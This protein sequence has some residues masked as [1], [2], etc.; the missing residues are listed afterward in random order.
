MR[1]ALLWLLT[2]TAI[3]SLLIIHLAG[4]AGVKSGEVLAFVLKDPASPDEVIAV[5][6]D[7]ALLRKHMITGRQLENE[8]TAFM[9]GAVES[10]LDVAL[11]DFFQDSDEE[12]ER[13]SEDTDR[14][15]PSSMSPEAFEEILESCRMEFRKILPDGSHRVEEL[16]RWSEPKKRKEEP[17]ASITFSSEPRWAGL[18]LIEL[19]GG[20]SLGV[21]RPLYSLEKVPDFFG[22]GFEVFIAEVP[23]DEVR[24][25]IINLSERESGWLK[26][27][28]R[29]ADLPIIEFLHGWIEAYN[30]GEHISGAVDL[31]ALCASGSIFYWK[32]IQKNS[33]GDISNA[34]LWI[35]DPDGNTLVIL[36][37]DT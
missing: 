29:P 25:L 20:G 27:P 30:V 31:N 14:F 12:P 37:C 9:V 35:L 1:N 7:E 24:T 2:T 10:A 22:D 17:T 32:K 23:G 19:P 11:G 18:S 16:I 36:N 15:I 21:T 26:G 5:F 33:S 3:I 4:G 6:V 28:V 34:E 13:V 8:F